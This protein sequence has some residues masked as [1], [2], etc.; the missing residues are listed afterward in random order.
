M[1]ECAGVLLAAMV[2][3]ALLG[4]PRY[5]LHPVRLMGYAAKL[6]EAVLRGLRLSGIIGGGVLAL[7]VPAA[8]MAGYFHAR[9]GLARVGPW[10]ALL[11]DTSA[12]YSCVAFK[13][14]LRHARPIASALESGDL[15][16]ARE[17]V[18]LIVGRDASVLS[19]EGVARAAVESVAE[20]FVDGILSPLFWFVAGAVAAHFAGIAPCTG[21]CLGAIAQRAVSTLDSMV[22]YR[23]ERYARFGWASA[24]LDDAMN[25]VPA[26]LAAASLFVAAAAL[27]FRALAGLKVFLRQRL[28]H[29]SPN[30]GHAESFVAGALD[31]KLGGPTAYPDGVVDKPWIGDGCEGAVAGDIRSACRLVGLAGWL[32]VCAAV[33]ALGTFTALARPEEL[34][35]LWG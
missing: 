8:F 9:L 25:F 32:A 21:G 10:P 33:G 29:P 30:A 16:V 2:L 18:G 17:R 15:P 3:D 22:G 12:V 28:S 6:L 27:R 14:L 5:P 20:S 19:A 35:R 4:D 26:R 31:L 34:S 11:L 24:R 1:P 7:A 23:N 13:D